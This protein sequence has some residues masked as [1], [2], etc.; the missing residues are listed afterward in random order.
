MARSVMSLLRILAVLL[1][2]GVVGMHAIPAAHHA[3]SAHPLAVIAPDVLAA[4]MPD[5]HVIGGEVHSDDGCDLACQSGVGVVML[6]LAVLG[7]GV[8]FV[9]VRVRSA[10]ALSLRVRPPPSAVMYRRLPLLRPPDLVAELCVS[11]T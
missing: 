9:F 1:I 8:A 10:R 6:C 5:H 2:V 7:T 3:A 11:R 4:V